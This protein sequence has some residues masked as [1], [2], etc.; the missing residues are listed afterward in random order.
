[1]QDQLGK[2]GAPIVAAS[3]WVTALPD[4]LAPWIDVPYLVLGTDGFGLSDTREALREFFSVDAKHITAAAMV[5]LARGG[6][7][8]PAEAAT[9]IKE[10]GI[11]PDRLPVFVLDR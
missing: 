10:L 5:A 7:R 3:D 11:D 2:G 1:M 4:L 6:E 9:A 8:T